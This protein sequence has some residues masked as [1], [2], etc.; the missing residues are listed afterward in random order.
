MNVNQVYLLVDL[1]QTHSFNQTAERLFT[2][3]QN[4]SYQIKQ[5]EQELGIRIFNR[6][7]SGVVF[8]EQGEYVLQCAYEMKQAYITMMEHL[9]LNEDRTAKQE[10]S[11]IKIYISSV[12]LSAKMTTVIKRFNAAFPAT[13]L[14]IK[15]VLQDQLIQSL[16]THKCDFAFWS[17]NKG[18]Y[19]QFHQKC[20]DR[21]IVSTLIKEDA[22][23][24]VISRRSPLVEKEMLSLSD[25]SHQ[26]KSV[27]GVLPWDYFQR[28]LDNLVLYEDDNIA[29]HKQLIQEENAIC[30]T[31][32]LV[33]DQLFA[34]GGFE[35]KPFD[36]PTLPIEHMVLKRKNL[37]ALA[38]QALEKII[39]DIL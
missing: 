26:P 23:V 11:Q 12:L 6:S 32:Q 38:L 15:E 22:A 4:V 36:Y 21:G 39:C 3:Q 25:L 37:D 29:I 8:T 18:Y 27:F 30:F 24:A 35:L 19:E 28:K 13:R 34:G 17:V 7:N 16:L 33:G 1:A 20:I 5:L 9:N 31:T 10:L 14:V 2:T